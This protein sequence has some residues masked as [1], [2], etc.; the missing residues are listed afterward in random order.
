MFIFLDLLVF[1]VIPSIYFYDKFLFNTN[2]VHN[3]ITN[4][5]LSVE[6]HS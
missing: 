3:I 2:E 5:V 1:R 6:F 4:D